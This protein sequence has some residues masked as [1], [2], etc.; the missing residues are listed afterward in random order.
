[1]PSA[2]KTP[3]EQQEAMDSIVGVIT[4]LLPSAKAVIFVCIRED[5]QGEMITAGKPSHLFAMLQKLNQSVVDQL[6]HEVLSEFPQVNS[7]AEQ[8]TLQ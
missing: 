3:Q 6:V 4:E 5:G 1:M 7:Q 8:P 2:I